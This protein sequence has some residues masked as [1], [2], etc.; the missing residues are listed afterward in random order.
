LGQ[1][2]VI[3]VIALASLLPPVNALSREGGT[4]ARD[5]KFALSPRDCAV[6]ATYARFVS[7]V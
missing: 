3:L 2:E 7:E 1:V 6:D 4:A 5:V